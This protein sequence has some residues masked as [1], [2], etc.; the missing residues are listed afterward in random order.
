MVDE[1]SVERV[2]IQ[3][4]IAKQ[5]DKQKAYYDQSIKSLIIYQPGDKVVLY[6]AVK[7]TSHTGK[8]NLKWKGLYYIH[9]RLRPDVYKLKTLDRIILSTLINGTLLK[10]YHKKKHWQPQIVINNELN[11]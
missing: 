7:H 10:L 6:K 8:L 5:Q 3:L 4:R 9:E 1:L 11:L 2:Q